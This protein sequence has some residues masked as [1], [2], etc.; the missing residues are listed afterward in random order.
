MLQV[1]G[2]PQQMQLVV[3]LAL[4]LHA[5]EFHLA[6]SAQQAQAPEFATAAGEGGV[7]GGESAPH[8]GAHCRELALGA[9]EPLAAING[10]FVA[11]NTQQVRQATR[12]LLQPQYS[13]HT[14]LMHP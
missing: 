10:S 6:E 9:H 7:G 3:S 13:L 1:L 5:A 12:A 4:A 8:A 2:S 11:R 14:P